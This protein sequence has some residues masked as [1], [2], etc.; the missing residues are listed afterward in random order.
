MTRRSDKAVIDT[1]LS[2]ADCAQRKGVTEQAI[3]AAIQRGA[4]PATKIGRTF[5]ITEADCDAYQ[6]VMDIRD[7]A[8]KKV[9]EVEPDKPKRGRGRPRKNPDMG[10]VI[11]EAS[12]G[13]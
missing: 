8:K 2:T 10:P 13:E 9:K 11:S 4:L 5:I 1:L 12:E 3:R 6:P 7:R